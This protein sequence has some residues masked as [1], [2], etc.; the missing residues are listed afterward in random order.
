MEAIQIKAFLRDTDLYSSLTSTR[1][2]RPKPKDDQ[3]LVQITHVSPHQVD[4]LFARGK[5]QNN[6]AKHGHVH[7]PFILGL[8]FAGIVESIP[9]RENIDGLTIDFKVGDSVM[10]QCYGAF[11]EYLCVQPTQIKKM[12]PSISPAAAAAL[13]GGVVSYAA[14]HQVAK[15]M[16]GETVLVTGANGGLGAVACQVARCSGAKVIGLVSSLDKVE[17]LKKD[18]GLD[19]VIATQDGSEWVQRVKSVCQGGGV[20]VM[21]DNVGLVKDGLRCLR[22]GGRIVIVGFAGRSGIMEEV[23][24]NRILLKGASVI[25]FV[26]SS[27][28]LRQLISA[29]I[30]YKRFG[31]QMRQDERYTEQVWKGYSEL[32]GTGGIKAVIDPRRYKGLKQV[33]RALQG[34][35]E[36]KLHGRAVVVVDGR[37]DAKL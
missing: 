23:G 29:N 18:L 2:P 25:G 35:A 36:R 5:H 9:S 11:A 33:P 3:L 4:L 14:V 37:E 30:H 26:R 20:D 16:A 27:L 28:S 10:G 34:L 32:L 7:P 22:Y 8:D 17:L 6:N 31:E 13:V 19:H 21:I 24:M 1:V 12:T 15:V